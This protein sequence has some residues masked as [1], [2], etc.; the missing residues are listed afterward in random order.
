MKILYLHQ[1]FSTPSGSAGTRS[2]EFARRLIARGHEVTM[3]CG[4]YDMADSGLSG[5]FRNGIRRGLVDGIDV[6]EL[7]IPFSNRQ[8]I[9]ARIGNFLRFSW[10]NVMMALREPYDLVFATST[11]LTVA[12]PALAARWLHRKPMVFEVRDLWPEMPKA[13]G[14]IRNPLLLKAA[15]ALELAAYRNASKC[16][17]LSPGIAEG[18][19]ARG[20]APADIVVV[21]NGA[22]LDL[23]GGA[24]PSAADDMVSPPLA[25]GERLLVFT[26]AHGAANG[27]EAVLN[28]AE[29]LQKRGFD[30]ARILLVGNGSEKQRLIELA[31]AKGLKNVQF[32][33]P[34]PKYK[35]A[36]LLRRADFG[37]MILKNLPVFYRG[38]SPNKFFDYLSAGL[39]IVINYPGWMAQ[40]V[41]DEKCGFVVP[42][43]DPQAFAD[44]IERACSTDTAE[45]AGNA[46]RLAEASF[47]RDVLAE[48]FCETLEQAASPGV[49]G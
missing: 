41:Q 27:L 31:R 49:R 4:R 21:P 39:P 28:A 43:D 7:D 6:V 42:P 24:D 13:M 29:V 33:D 34:V 2:Y 35:L 15:E 19:A 16:V 44:A 17:A 9:A 45:M 10:R 26:G 30:D 48:R 47:N 11:P 36:S 46:R 14:L 32:H 22:D 3:V 18:I 8:P 40:M 37:L 20:I 38:T 5:P 25:E 12:I 1:Y 23:F